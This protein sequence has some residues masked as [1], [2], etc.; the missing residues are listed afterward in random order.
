MVERRFP[1]KLTL[2]D[3][4]SK[5]GERAAVP[6]DVASL[7][8][9]R[10]MND[11]WDDRC[12]LLPPEPPREP[13]RQD[14]VLLAL[15]DLTI[16]PQ[17]RYGTL[18]NVDTAVVVEAR[19]KQRLNTGLA[20]VA[21]YVDATGF[22]ALVGFFPAHLTGELV[23][24]SAS[25]WNA[26]HAAAHNAYLLAGLFLLGVLASV[27]LARLLRKRG[28]SPYVP[29]LMLLSSTLC[30]LV[31]LGSLQASGFRFAHFATLAACSLSFA[32]GVQNA[33]MRH[34]L[35]GTLPTTVMTGNLTQFISELVDLG[36]ARLSKNPDAEK[37]HQT[38]HRVHVL[39]RTLACFFGGAFAGAAITHY[40]GLPSV[41]LPAIAAGYLTY[42][43][44]PRSAHGE[45]QKASAHP[46]RA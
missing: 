33:V 13:L 11:N 14:S 40:V 26:G 3:A 30:G 5:S 34:A 39:G 23:S 7:S 1:H 21:G 36:M 22:V 24:I 15:S 20:G 32:M 6:R 17:P 35:N 45:R 10:V 28:W 19:L 18:S 37:N 25:P 29:Q 46:K 42:L 2:V 12:G 43:A 27:I 16:E 41:A 9:V 4:P 38:V 8:R 44:W 31:T